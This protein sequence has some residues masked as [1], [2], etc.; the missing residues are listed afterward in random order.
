MFLKAT[1]RESFSS[2]RLNAEITVMKGRSVDC[3]V[4]A[5]FFQNRSEE[6]GSRDRYERLGDASFLGKSGLLATTTVDQNVVSRKLS[7]SIGC[8]LHSNFP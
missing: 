4:I 3:C 6:F 2:K 5:V 1:S 7:R 8:T